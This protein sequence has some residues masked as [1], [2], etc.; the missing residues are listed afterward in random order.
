MPVSPHG[1]R[2]RTALRRH[3]R[4]ARRR[5]LAQGLLLA[6]AG[7]TVAA[8]QLAL[9][10]GWPGAA[11]VAVKAP[12]TLLLLG[13][14]GW[15]LWELVLRPLGRLGGPRRFAA[16]LDRAGGYRNV[17]VAAEESLRRPG[18]W[19]GP[20]V[21]AG[22]TDRLQ[23]DAA[24]HL[25]ALR[26]VETL[27]LP[28][29]RPVLLLT[30]AFLGLI[31]LGA[32]LHGPALLRGGLRLLTPLRVE[33]RPPA[34]GLHLAVVPAEA[35]AG[36]R[37][38]VTAHDLGTPRG[39]VV[40]EVRSGRGAWRTLST[41][42]LPSWRP[43]PYDVYAATLADLDVDL[44]VRF[45][46]DG[47][48]TEA[49]TL[50][51]LHPPLL[52][53]LAVEIAPPAYTGLPVQDLSP[54]PAALDALAGSRLSWRGRANR[55]VARA[56]ILTTDGDT[57]AWHAAGDSIHGEM[58]AAEPLS[59]R[60]RLSDARGLS[61]TPG[62]LYELAVREDAPPRV[63]LRREGHDGLLPGDGRLDLTVLAE[64]DFGVAGLDLLL[65][66]EAGDHALQDTTWTRIAILPPS[67]DAAADTPL[68]PAT[69]TPTLEEGRAR[70]PRVV[71]RLGADVSALELLPGDVLAL[72]AEARDT[73]RPAPP[74]RARSRVMRFFL[75]SAAD[76]LASQALTEEE[77]LAE[78][79]DLRRR[80]GDV[81]EEL[82]R[83]RRELLKNPDP[84]FA[85]RQEIDETLSRQQEMQSELERMTEDLRRDLDEA[86][87]RNLATSE[88]VERMDRV[89]DLMD[90]LRNE[91]LDAL[92]EQLSE[93]MSQLDEQ[94]LREA[95]AEVAER[96]QEF[97]DRL[98][99]TIA[100]LEELKRE[101]EMSGL[102]AMLEEMMRRQEEIMNAEPGADPS[103][104][105]QQA[106]LNEELEALKERIAE[107]LEDLEASSSEAPAPSDDAMREALEQAMEM[108]ESGE[109]EKAL[110]QAA[111]EMGE[112][113]PQ[114]DGGDAAHE[115]MRRMAAL[116][117]VLLEGQQGMQSAMQDFA[118]DVLRRV[119]SELIGISRRQEALAGRIPSNLRDVRAPEL[120][121]EQ[122]RLLRATSAL[123]DGLETAMASSGQVAFGLLDALD[124]A[125]DVLSDSVEQLEA[126]Y[127]R[128]AGDAARR[129]LGD[130]NALVVQLLTSAQMTGQGSGSCPMPSP[131][132]GQQLERMARE[133]A[134][135]NGLTEQMRQQLNEAQR[136]DQQ[137]RQGLQRLQ[138]QQQGLAEGVREAAEQ[139]REQPEGERLL[140]DLEELARDM[141][142]VADDLG[143]GH[144]DEEVL[145]RQERILSRMLD[146]HN[147]VRRRDYAKRRESRQAEGIYARQAGEEGDGDAEA[148][149]APLR[150]RPEQIER[151]PPEYRDLVRRYFRALRELE[152]D[153]P[154]AGGT[155]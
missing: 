53:G 149:V 105:E 123:R 152:R 4:A 27:G 52:A 41:E 135:L 83:I 12:C 130:L 122:Q 93:A 10:V 102:A 67:G 34:A 64:D 94:Q 110:E 136:R 5:T 100:L 3:L 59:W 33:G 132:M 131:A 96:Q 81:S 15:L 48:T 43:R 13:I 35:P 97:L 72:A 80:S 32:G 78:L 36:S 38:Q 17:L 107:A 40:C 14:G 128:Q 60:V 55:A 24:A 90:E 84:D 129:G 137:S 44:E 138:S 65:R 21:L 127:G 79:E 66:R 75:P 37:V 143:R 49:R 45:T 116:Y 6:G 140:G 58:R 26:S 82:D 47:M 91:A 57:L 119:A 153:A 112:T 74:G 87:L 114:P 99:R 150:L 11:P 8:A 117:H 42:K 104:A 103:A 39:P 86:A 98:D 126:G 2:F 118:G 125:A 108:L 120:P 73:R 1:Q 89:A 95:M 124:R 20:D 31:A 101:Q 85:R 134:G 76:L 88:M 151:V 9:A 7:T 16:G 71:L 121:R 147:S 18:R 46:R 29:W 144:V 92:R 155:P 148:G 61:S 133:Q 139:E 141:E 62:V 23:A 19:R 68:G 30:A 142:R 111:R 51:V 63:A 69:L 106:A 70:A 25:T 77:R 145:R 154:V 50:R 146:A 115:A 22:C 56:E 109:L 54:A 28:R 113:P